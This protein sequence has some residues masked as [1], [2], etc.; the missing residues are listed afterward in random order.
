MDRNGVSEDLTSDPGVPVITFIH[1]IKLSSVKP[2]STVG[3]WALKPSGTMVRKS[4]RS[5]Q[6]QTAYLVYATIIRPEHSEGG[7][8]KR[9]EVT[10]SDLL[11]SALTRRR[12][13]MSFL[14]SYDATAQSGPWP[15]L[16]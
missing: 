7:T 16:Y 4:D 5:N 8:R 15:P 10:H 12:L 9:N 14:P 13:T 6:Q 1:I 2:S 3:V 11:T